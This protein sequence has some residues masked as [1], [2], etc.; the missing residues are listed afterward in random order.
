MKLFVRFIRNNLNQVVHTLAQ[1]A[2][3][4]T[5]CVQPDW[6]YFFNILTLYWRLDFEQQNNLLFVHFRLD[7]KIILFLWVISLWSG[8]KMKSFNKS[9][10]LALLTILSITG[11]YAS[12]GLETMFL[13]FVNVDA[14][15]QQTKI[16]HC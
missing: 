2:T 9:I 7:S 6:G 10:L 1:P 14:Y 3:R 16:P 5:Q 15:S 11:S 4:V 12:K 13:A 8:Q